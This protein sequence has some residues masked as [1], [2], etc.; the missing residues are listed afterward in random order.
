MWKLVLCLLV[1]LGALVGSPTARA[2]PGISEIIERAREAQEAEQLATAEYLYRKALFVQP[3][4]KRARK[5]LRKVAEK[6]IAELLAQA[7]QVRAEYPDTAASYGARALE[8]DPD[9]KEAKALLESA[10]YVQIRGEWVSPEYAKRLQEQGGEGRREELRLP[11]IFQIIEVDPLRFFTNVDV[12]NAKSVLTQAINANV[13]HLREYRRVF[14]ALG[15][16]SPSEGIDIVLFNTREEYARRIRMSGTAGVYI[17]SER[18]GFFFRDG[19]Y[20]FG[21]ML[22]EMTHQLNDKLL[23]VRAAAWFEEGISEY[24][25]SAQLTQQGKRIEVGRVDGTR[26]ATFKRMVREGDGY[27]PLEKFVLYPQS[28]LTGEFYSEAWAFAHFLMEVHPEGRSILFD[29]IASVG[30][31]GPRL[32]RELRA[33]PEI[34]QAHGLTLDALE[35]QMKAYYATGK[36]GVE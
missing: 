13:S 31:L 11:P 19:G 9:C 5:E 29:Y 6:R 21:T 35:S 25:G 22:H 26:L 33:L 36:L 18:A 2:E 27:I 12:K 8:I 7:E 1:L 24:F 20:D 3:R 4:N 34:V 28:E 17:P 14:D 23:R 15:L 30:P 10:G 32:G 16:R